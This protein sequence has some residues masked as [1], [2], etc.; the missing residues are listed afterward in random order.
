MNVSMQSVVQMAVIIMS[1]VVSQAVI[2]C[3]CLYLCG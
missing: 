3:A 2:G 1:M